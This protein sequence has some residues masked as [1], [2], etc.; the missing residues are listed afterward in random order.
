MKTGKLIT[1][2]EGHKTNGFGSEIAAIVTEEAIEYLE[3]PIFRV[4]A[5]MVP[6][7]YGPTLEKFYIPDENNIKEAVERVMAYG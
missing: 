2:D 4:A 3:A 1:V 5:P 7:P 6:V